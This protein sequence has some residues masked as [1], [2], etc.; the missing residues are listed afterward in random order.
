MRQLLEEEGMCMTPFS[1]V[2]AGRVCRM[3]EDETDRC[4]SDKIAMVKYD[5]EKEMDLPIVKR[6]KELADK[7]KVTMAQI[8]MAW[9]LNK[10]LVAS[11]VFG[12]TKIQQL[13]D[14]CKAVNIKL[15]DDDMKYLEELYRPHLNM[16]AMLKDQ[17]PAYVKK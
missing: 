4:K 14:L 3:W 7:Y 2:A 12:A 6:I 10:K 11:P 9:I 8:S 1:P 5:Q 13:E 17:G 15:S 16:G